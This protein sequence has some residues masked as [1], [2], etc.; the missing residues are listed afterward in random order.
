MLVCIDWN[1][2]GYKKIREKVCALCYP[3]LYSKVG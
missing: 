1:W 3:S 2:E